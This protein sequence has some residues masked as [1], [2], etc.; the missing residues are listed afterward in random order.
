MRKSVIVVILMLIFCIEI[1]A[2]TNRLYFI[3]EGHP[4]SAI[5]IPAHAE[6]WTITA[7][8]WLKDYMY[9]ASGV[10]LAIVPESEV[11]TGTLIS[12]GHT[13]L[14]K[15]AGIT[16]DDL[17]YDGC[18]LMVKDNVLYLI[19]RDTV[20]TSGKNPNVGARGTC[21]A[22][23]TFLEEMCRIR[24]FLPGPE[25]E[26]IP[27]TNS[28]SAP[29]N[30]DKS[31]IPA[32]AA[33]SARYPYGEST[34]AS[35]ANNF[36][37]TIENIRAGETY[38]KMLPTGTWK[39]QNPSITALY[40]GRPKYF[41]LHPEYFAFIDGKRT[42]VGNH[43]CSTNPEVR[44]ILL[45]EVRKRFEEGYSIVPLGQEDGYA[46][47]Q[48][49]ECER[50][51]N[52]RGWGPETGETWDDF[53]DRLKENPCERVLL[54]HKWIIDECRKSH[55]DKTINLL[56]YGPTLY[57]S[58]KFDTFGDNVIATIC[59]GDPR[60]AAAWKDKVKRLSGYCYWFD[61]TLPMGMDIH[62]TPK[63]VA[64]GIRT[65]RDTGYIALSQFAEANW[66]L[67]GP[68]FYEFGRLL[69][70]PD[71]DYEPIIGEYC[72]GVYGN[73][74]D[75]MHSFYKLLYSR[76]DMWPLNK[77][78]YG[79]LPPRWMS[80]TDIYLTVYTP[81]FLMEL[82]QLL[83]K[84]ESEAETERSKGWLKLTR[85]HFDFTKLLTHALI[86]Y[87][88]Y[89][90]S[91]TKENRHDV[92]QA[93]DAFNAYRMKIIS[94]PKEYTDIWFPGHDK[95]CNYLTSEGKNEQEIYYVPWETR[96]DKYIRDGVKGLA[97]GFQGGY[98]ERAFFKPFTLEFNK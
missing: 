43:L 53:Y 69:G 79:K 12:V 63:E 27:K 64:G 78:H 44:H 2:E 58:K 57:P 49:P 19:G 17:I 50:M 76:H 47:C 81:P 38:Y 56:V 77:G 59:S 96:K 42:D 14:A 73:S 40:K 71:M 70:N 31:C 54:L 52:Y 10:E 83:D 72:H 3:R 29:S 85:D 60:V 75:T 65:M 32:F 45:N 25:G 33:V 36:R 66:G 13:K 18:K 23:L 39:S 24:W 11:P 28:I 37:V 62:A 98:N 67:Q 35:L 55:P 9:K 46:R 87:R 84:A 20:S 82:E 92:K 88:A 41:E 94:Y 95:F 22:V 51:D 7:G 4:V 68:L 61:M 30:L 91:A 15:K 48:C 97:V 5:V 93:V 34:P 8:T 1:K 89:Q 6:K 80:S 74:G 90:M 26:F 16:T 21:R 86:S